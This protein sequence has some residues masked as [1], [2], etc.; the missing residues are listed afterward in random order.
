MREWHGHF[1]GFDVWESRWLAR[2]IGPVIQG[3]GLE[4]LRSADV[5]VPTAHVHCLVGDFS[6]LTLALMCQPG[7]GT[8]GRM[9]YFERET[10]VAANAAELRS[11]S[12]LSL[13]DPPTLRQIVDAYSAD[14]DDDLGNLVGLPDKLTDMVL[15]ASYDSDPS[16][17]AEAW[18][19]AVDVAGRWRNPPEGFGSTRVWLDQL[20]ARSEDRPRLDALLAQR[21]QEM[22]LGGVRAEAY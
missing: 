2:R 16:T 18:Q 3:I 15:I 8:N 14:I 4:R 19:H 10:R 11:K 9:L 22:R 12:S 5:Y 1:P 20:R 21:L 6:V 17:L 7:N 13:D